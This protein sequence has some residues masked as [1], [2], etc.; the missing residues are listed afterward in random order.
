VRLMLRV[1]QVRR[2]NKNQLT[3]LK[4]KAYSWIAINN[5]YRLKEDKKKYNY[6]KS[7][8]EKDEYLRFLK[9]DEYLQALKK[10]YRFLTHLTLKLKTK[11]ILLVNLD[12]KSGLVNGSQGKVIDFIESTSFS[13]SI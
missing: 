1:E 3:I 6:L 8:K 9:E 12:I 13:G 10:E 11:V 5:C 7:L 4:T 2:F